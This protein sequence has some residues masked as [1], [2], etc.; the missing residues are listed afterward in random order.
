MIVIRS[1]TLED[2]YSGQLEPVNHL[3]RVLMIKTSVYRPGV[4]IEESTHKRLEDV[5][6]Q[7]VRTRNMQC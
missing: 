7:Q 4:G 2:C 3:R 5:T 6:I 1:R